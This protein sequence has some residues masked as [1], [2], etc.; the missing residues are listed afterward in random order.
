VTFEAG[1][2]HATSPCTPLNV[3]PVSPLGDDG[4][5]T[6]TRRDGLPLPHTGEWER[7]DLYIIKKI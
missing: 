2:P 4:G 1:I 3:K 5:W 6:I 7:D